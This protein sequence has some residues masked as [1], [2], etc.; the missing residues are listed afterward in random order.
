MPHL[1]YYQTLTDENISAMDK[2]KTL[3]LL[4]ISLLE[5]HGP[6]L[7]LGTDFLI[8]GR[9]AQL[10]GEKIE[11]NGNG[12]NAVLLPAVP[13]GAGGIERPG[14]LNH[15]GKII[16]KVIFEFGERLAEYGFKQGAIVSGHAGKNHLQAMYDAA[17]KL[18]R[19]AKFEFLPLTSYLF[20][21]TGMKKMA[22][23]LESRHQSNPDPQLP[24]YDGH[25]G[26]WETSVM[27]Y[28]FPELVNKDYLTLPPSSDA[29]QNGYRASKAN[30]ELGHL[31]VSFLLEIAFM[32]MKKHFPFVK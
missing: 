12:A 11:K 1:S 6:H 17:R 2:E 9:F 23:E 10:I 7:P 8:A 32:I 20:L 22:R 26:L 31:L 21:D 19:K 16:E 24:E 14:T 3:V 5:A 28:L 15:N 13:L 27:L 29:D 18:K 4:P 30:K 25:A